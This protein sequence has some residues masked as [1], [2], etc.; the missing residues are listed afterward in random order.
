[1]GKTFKREKSDKPRLKPLH[2]Y[3]NHPYS[4]EEDDIWDESGNIPEDEITNGETIHP[5]EQPR[6]S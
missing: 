4:K 6:R 3:V 2:S 1:M 5:E